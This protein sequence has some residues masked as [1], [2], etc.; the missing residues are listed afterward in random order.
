MTLPYILILTLIVEIIA[1][2]LSEQGI[3]N[4]LFYNLFTV[5]YFIVYMHIIKRITVSPRVRKVIMATIFIYSV[6]ALINIFFIQG[7]EVFHTITY[8]IGSLLVIGFCVHFF[9]ELFKLPSS[10]DLKKYPAFWFV[11]ALLFFYCC[12]LPLAGLTNFIGEFAPAVVEN[13]S[14]I[15]EVI[16]SLVYSLFTIALL[17]RRNMR[18]SM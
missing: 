14:S 10:V 11:T 8:S 3:N 7:K 4:A 17:C 6:V 18:K 5:A 12:A 16:N 1:W 15:L 2:R 9:Y 13:L